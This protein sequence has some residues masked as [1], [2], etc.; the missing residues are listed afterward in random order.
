MD[1]NSYKTINAKKTTVEKGWVLVDAKDQVL[2]RVASQVAR[3][4][5]GKHKPSYTP[6]V[7][8]GDHVVV[9]NA[10]KIRMT[11]K[12]WTDRV[13]FSYSG[14][15]GGQ[16]VLTPKMIGTGKHPERLV[17]HSVRGMLPKN[18]LGREI[19]RSLHV[20]AGAEHPHTAQQPKEIKF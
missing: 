4:L 12:K 10:D 2:G 11:G 5:R 6:N 15:P 8:T 19:F 9:I 1:H 17:E 20:Y 7:D 13:Y 14:Y 16:R 3:V 18:S